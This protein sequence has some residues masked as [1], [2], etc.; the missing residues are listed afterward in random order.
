MTAQPRFKGR[1]S[2]IC[3][4]QLTRTSPLRRYN[5]GA[6]TRPRR[7]PIPK[8]EARCLGGAV[9][10]DILSR[11]THSIPAVGGDIARDTH[12]ES[13]KYSSVLDPRVTSVLLTH[14]SSLLRTVAHGTP[15]LWDTVCG[16]TRSNRATPG[17]RTM[18]VRSGQHPLSITI[19]NRHG[20]PELVNLNAP[21]LRFVWEFC[22]R[23]EHLVLDVWAGCYTNST[24][25][26]RS[27]RTQDQCRS[28]SSLRYP[29]PPISGSLP[30]RPIPAYPGI[31]RSYS[32]RWRSNP[33]GQISLVPVDDLSR[34]LSMTV[35]RFHELL[36]GCRR[37][38]TGYFHNLNA[39]P[40]GQHPPCTLD[41]LNSL[42]LGA[43]SGKPVVEFFDSLTLPSLERL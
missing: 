38:E 18:L 6:D 39:S 1:K 3:S 2:N 43:T 25:P 22:I 40:V 26:S 27:P 10:E 24:A 35:D 30:G 32:T 37:L 21:F 12:L 31:R 4:I 34:I 16:T 41:N 13:H 17:L 23:I 19:A 8:A 33:Y 9:K 20:L 7:A 5:R 28:R 42:N 29:T 11:S 15:R 36:R 14:I